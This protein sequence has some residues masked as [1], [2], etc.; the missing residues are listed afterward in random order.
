[1]STIIDTL[2]KYGF[3]PSTAEIYLI[4]ANN[5][6]MTVPQITEKT[7]FS[8]ASIYDSLGQLLAQD[9]L[10]YRKEGRVAYYKPMH[11]NKLFGLIEQ[12]KR[13]TT[14]LEEEMKDSIRTLSGAYSLIESKPGVKFFEGEEEIENALMETL[15]TD[16]EILT[17]AEGNT[18]RTYLKEV[19][20]RYVKARIEKKVFK[21]IISTD[22]SVSKEHH[23]SLNRTEFTKIKYIDPEK[24][25]FETS[26]QIYKNSVL[27]LTL[28]ETVKIGFL[29]KDKKVADFHRSLF[30]FIWGHL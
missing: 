12:K 16:G 25:P 3:E 18:I 13:D 26:V 4:L 1:M 17:F 14:L 11:P 8:R 23:T 10:E 27:Y 20:E 2:V 24:Y 22:T 29:I 28:S 30:A 9:Y 6:E 15:Q 21:R 7:E 5:G 19:N